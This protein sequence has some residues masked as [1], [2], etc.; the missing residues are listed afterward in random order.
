MLE[1][2]L[3][4]NAGQWQLAFRRPKTYSFDAVLYGIHD[5]VQMS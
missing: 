2:D 5:I 4:A 3:L 1:S